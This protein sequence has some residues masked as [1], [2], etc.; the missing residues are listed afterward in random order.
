QGDHGPVAFRNIRYKRTEAGEVTLGPMDFAWYPGAFIDVNDLDITTAE[1]LVQGETDLM[2]PTIS[3]ESGQGL[4]VL[5]GTIEVPASGDYG[6][7]VTAGGGAT[8]VSVDGEIVSHVWSNPAGVVNLTPGTHLIETKYIRRW[9]GGE[10]DFS[11]AVEGPEMAPQLLSVQHGEMEEPPEIGLDVEDRTLVQRGFVKH[12]GIMRLSGVSVGTPRGLHYAY[13]L[14]G[15]APL[16]VW[17][18]DFLD[19][20][21]MWHHR[22]EDQIAIPRGGAIELVGVPT[23]SQLPSS[24]TPWPTH[25]EPALRQRG[26]TRDA[27]G[28]PT[29]TTQLGPLL[30]ADQITPLASGAGLHRELTLQG[31]SMNHNPRLMIAASSSISQDSDGT[32][33]IGEREYYLEWLGARIAP[34]ERE[35]D[36]STEP[37]PDIP[38]PVIRESAGRMEMTIEFPHDLSETKSVGY[39]LIW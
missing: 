20:T 33:V 10:P 31:R 4:L 14:A 5:K 6:F 39:N 13:D 32:Y 16:K 8:Q 34:P 17:R 37:A 29:F 36:E 9:G 28:R 11:V 15:G 12:A 27:G 23:L 26:Y 35:E 18:G 25:P 7:Q 22:G 21:K 3:G 19:M 2:D 30:I 38:E 24:K 1:P